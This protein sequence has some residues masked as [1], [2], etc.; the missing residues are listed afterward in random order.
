MM[1][2][3][4]EKAGTKIVPTFIAVYDESLYTVTI[5]CFYQNTKLSSYYTDT[6]GLSREDIDYFKKFGVK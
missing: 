6:S 5:Y 2:A 3:A 4:A 1:D